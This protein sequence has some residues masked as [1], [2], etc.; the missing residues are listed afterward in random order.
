MNDLYYVLPTLFTDDDIDPVSVL[1]ICSGFDSENDSD[2]NII[3][4]ND[5]S[6]HCVFNPD[7]YAEQ[8]LPRPNESVL[9]NNKSC[10]GNNF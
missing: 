5:C 2:T 10:F 3:W 9:Q 8:H 4:N 6:K 1:N 7:C